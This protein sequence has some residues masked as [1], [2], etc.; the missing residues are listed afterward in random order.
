MSNFICEQCGVIQY[1]SETGYTSGC[2]HY[3]PE[4]V[5]TVL[6][7]FGGDGSHDKP[8]FYDERYGGW[9]P[10]NISGSDPVHPVAWRNL[11]D[12]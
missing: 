10:T 6:M 8:G 7:L 11:D 3:P 2:Q 12:R 1:D 5:R 9:Y 4:S